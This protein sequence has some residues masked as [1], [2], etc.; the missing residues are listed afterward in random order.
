MDDG[1]RYLEENTNELLKGLEDQYL[2]YEQF[3][4]DFIV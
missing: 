1:I 2:D 3:K 4:K